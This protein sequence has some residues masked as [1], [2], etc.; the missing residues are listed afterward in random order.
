MF[1]NELGSLRQ[2]GR[3]E[4]TPAVRRMLSIEELRYVLLRHMSSG[5]SR[6]ATA[7]SLDALSGCRVLTAYRT[8]TGR[9]IFVITEGD[10]TLTTLLLPQEC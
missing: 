3:V 9:T 6:C 2:L 4:L 1:N 5:K 8:R 7:C 10:R